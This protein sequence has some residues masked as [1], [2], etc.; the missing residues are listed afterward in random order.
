MHATHDTPANLV[1]NMSNLDTPFLARGQGTN[2]GGQQ[3]LTPLSLTAESL[4]P[5]NNL[6]GL[7]PN[8]VVQSDITAAATGMLSL[9]R[10][11]Q[12][13]DRNAFRQVFREDNQVKVSLFNAVT[14]FWGLQANNGILKTKVFSQHV[15]A[16]LDVLFHRNNPRV[17]LQAMVFV[18]SITLTR[19]RFQPLPQNTNGINTPFCAILVK[20]LEWFD[21]LGPLIIEELI[22]GRQVPLRERDLFT[23]LK[24][25]II[26]VMQKLPE[27]CRF[28]L[29]TQSEFDAILMGKYREYWNRMKTTTPGAERVLWTNAFHAIEDIQAAAKGHSGRY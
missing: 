25:S 16:I 2:S 17:K 27:S 29:N 11:L 22:D 13:A 12:G 14:Y 8:T 5:T 1:T 15:V 3:Q 26:D 21:P 24:D 7:D 20:L 23:G 4:K 28:W 18:R 9:L 6:V 19:R 10:R